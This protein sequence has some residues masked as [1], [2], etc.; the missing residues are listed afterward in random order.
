L[1]STGEPWCCS[2]HDRS[3][4]ETPLFRVGSVL[5]LDASRPASAAKDGLAA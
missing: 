2:L 3:Q 1:A 5:R 4:A